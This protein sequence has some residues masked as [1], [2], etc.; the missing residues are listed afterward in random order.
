[1]LALHP[2]FGEGFFEKPLVINIEK[3]TCQSTGVTFP[4]RKNKIFK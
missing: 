1:M 3:E 2:F 4:K